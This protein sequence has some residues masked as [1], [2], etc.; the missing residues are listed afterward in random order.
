MSWVCER[1]ESLRWRFG[2]AKMEEGG[3]FCPRAVGHSKFSLCSGMFP[4]STHSS[5][6]PVCGVVEVRASFGLRAT[7]LLSQFDLC[8]DSMER[9]LSEFETEKQRES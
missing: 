3:S 1:C 6:E 2:Q 8:L 5:G 7:G 9:D 4:S